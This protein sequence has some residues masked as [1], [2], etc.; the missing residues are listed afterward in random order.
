MERRGDKEARLGNG[1]QRAGDV[2]RIERLAGPEGAAAVQ[3]EQEGRFEAIA[4]LHRNS[5]DDG[6]RL[7]VETERNGFG[8]AVG[9]E[10]APGLALGL[11]QAG[12]AGGEQ[13]GGKVV[14]GKRWNGQFRSWLIF[15]VDRRNGWKIDARQVERIGGA[16][17]QANQVGILGLQ[18]AKGFRRLR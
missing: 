3:G 18:A 11:W 1:G 5:A 16:V 17:T 2:L 13:D 4:V 9:D 14:G 15:P 6:V 8:P 12:R 7:A 10:F